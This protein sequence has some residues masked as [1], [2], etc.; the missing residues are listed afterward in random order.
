MNNIIDMDV[1]NYTS[2]EIKQLELDLQT[3]LTRQVFIKIEILDQTDKVIDEVSGSAISGNYN[4]DST[5]AIRRTCSITFN[6][7]NGYLPSES[8][9]FWIN[10][11][12][13]L[14]IGLKEM[15]TNSVYWFNKGTY[16]I[17]DPS[18]SIAINENTITINGLD[19]MALY[20]GDISGQLETAFIADVVDE[21]G[22]KVDIYVGDAV[23]ALMR[24][25]GETN[26][27]I[28]KTDLVLPYKI[29]SAIGD[30]RYDILSKFN[31]LFY[32]YQ[33]YY[34]LDGYFVF[35]KKPA[36]QSNDKVVNEIA[37]DFSKDSKDDIN[38]RISNIPYNLLISINRDIAYSNIKNK[39]IVYGGIHD[40]GYQPK[41]EII[42]DDVNFPDSP[43]T[44][45]KLDERYSDNTLMFRQ[46]V[47]QDDM[48][49]D[50]GD[51][52]GGTEE[53]LIPKDNYSFEMATK[54]NNTFVAFSQ[55]I[56]PSYLSPDIPNVNNAWGFANSTDEVQKQCVHYDI[57]FDDT[58]YLDCVPKQYYG[59]TYYVG[60]VWILE[61]ILKSGD[62]TEANDTGEPFVCWYDG[63][64]F[65]IYIEGNI[66]EAETTEHIVKFTRKE[67]TNHAYSFN[68]CKERAIQEV[69]LHQQ[70]T[71]TVQIV[72]VPIYSLDVN[73][74]IYLD[75]NES[76]VQG[77]YV[78]TNISC[79]LGVSDTMSITANKLW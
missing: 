76:G 40:D 9:I 18:V 17:K 47:V 8:S 31:E 13:R 4:I 54:G 15:R 50:A 66:S 75:D 71:D 16:A 72:C 6:L 25:G 30:T 73:T 32:N 28:T 45:K 61:Q 24:D 37:I 27:L 58:S 19:K 12:F 68:L 39:V 67:I 11:R 56:L 53:V 46:F 22:E 36:Y 20:N 51:E 55:I 57:I 52:E 38:S 60:N 34:N 5:S 10:K 48:Y 35:G 7:K 1:S 77:E 79:G 65:G 59:N 43:Y 70:A 63:K 78:I 74:V 64:N 44:I 42:V 41:Y 29:E 2:E 21:S 69:Y 49:V 3:R 33:V 26:L 23:E 62:Y 14:Y